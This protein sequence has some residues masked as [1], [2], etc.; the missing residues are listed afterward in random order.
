MKKLLI[1]TAIIIT[2]GLSACKDVEVDVPKFI[3]VNAA[4]SLYEI[5]D[6]ELN[7]D[8]NKFNLFSVNK[9]S[10]AEGDDIYITTK[11]TQE[12]LVIHLQQPL[13]D[14]YEIIS[15]DI[16]YPNGSTRTWSSMS[17]EFNDPDNPGRSMST[18]SD[19][20]QIYIPIVTP[21]ISG[22]VTYVVNS[23]KYIDGVDIKDVVKDTTNPD[24]IV[25]DITVY[26]PTISNTGLP[27]YDSVTG[28]LAAH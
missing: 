24:Y 18:N 14:I 27:V 26:S 6:I 10:A 15:V 19:Y 21:D 7:I 11:E 17:T 2:L 4:P 8:D 22:E 28:I 9:V 23:I 16:S 25:L 20:T 13:D 5:E 3:G 12:W 1:V